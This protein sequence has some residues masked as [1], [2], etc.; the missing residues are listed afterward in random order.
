[1]SKQYEVVVIGLGGM[2]SAA[3]YHLARRK[4]RVLGIEQFTSPHDRGSSHGKSRIIRQAYFED[5]AYVPLVFRAY[6]LWRELETETNRALLTITG[7]LMI[8]APDSPIIKGS[9]QSA[10][11]YDIPHEM[12][13]SHELKRRYPQLK[14]PDHFAALYERMA[15]YVNPE[16]T[17]K[18]H[19]DA[20]ESRGAEIHFEESVIRWDADGDRV[21][22]KTDSD[23][24]EAESLVISAG[25]WA[26][27][28][29]KDLHFP[30]SVE[31][32]VMYWFDPIGGIEQF[33][34]ER[35]P[36][37][38]WQVEEGIVYGFPAHGDPKEGVKIGHHTAK[39]ACTPQT[40][41]RKVSGDEIELMR[42]CIAKYIP[43]LGG[44]CLNAITC[45]YTMTPDEHFIIG[46]H[47]NHR[48]TAIAAGFSG[49]GY[50]FASAVGEILA[51]LITEGSTKL[52]IELFAP[53]RF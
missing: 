4:R 40:I 45:M 1:M 11:A 49:H 13:D 24:Y 17:V 8:G 25:P 16:E 42:Q 41:D 2:G 38:V 29:L 48:R 10:L 5:P 7:G 15:G 43:S 3:L 28:I 20:A 21:K 53:S 51:D 47:P 35:L 34:A 39:S 9:S 26:P 44:D 46:L 52:S 6:E 31:R 19:L 32:L 22:V 14:A 23:E 50:K 30:L 36:I 37:H 18:A 33:K 27:D 12:L